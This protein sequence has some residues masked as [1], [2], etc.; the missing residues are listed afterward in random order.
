MI[1]EKN[2]LARIQAADDNPPA[3]AYATEIPSNE[4]VTGNLLSRS[5]YNQTK[6][7]DNGNGNTGTHSVMDKAASANIYLEKIAKYTGIKDWAKALVKNVR[8]AEP[9]TQVGIGMGA[10]MGAGKVGNIYD[11]TKKHR[12]QVNYEERSLKTLQAINRNL[13]K[14]VVVKP[15]SNN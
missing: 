4:Y 12:N 3:S 8:E 1:T 15:I 2:I 7:E 5:A 9:L 14:A 11:S 13:N 10:L 6:E